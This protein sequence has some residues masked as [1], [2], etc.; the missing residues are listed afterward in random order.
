MNRMSE[1]TSKNL[2]KAD[3]IFQRITGIDKLLYK[4]DDDQLKDFIYHVV[5]SRILFTDQEKRKYKFKLPLKPKKKIQKSSQ[6]HIFDVAHPADTAAKYFAENLEQV[7]ADAIRYLFIEAVY[8]C[9]S[10]ETEKGFCIAGKPEEDVF[11]DLLKYRFDEEKKRIKVQPKTHRKLY[12]T[13]SKRQELLEQYNELLPPTR[14]AKKSYRKLSEGARKKS[15]RIIKEEF[16]DLP[17]AL[18]NGISE[19]ISPKNIVLNYLATKFDGARP[20]YMFTM[21]IQARKE[22]AYKRTK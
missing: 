18:I 3:E 13:R 10:S 1:K 8:K 21:L 2:L 14:E 19:V 15:F 9:S 5:N 16:P 22:K 12:W 7:V 6:A 4:I 11:D 17:D 20:N